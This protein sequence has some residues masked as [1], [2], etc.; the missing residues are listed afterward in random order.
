MSP[1]RNVNDVPGLY[2]DKPPCHRGLCSTLELAANTGFSCGERACPALGGKAAPTPSP[3]STRYTE[4]DGFGSAAQPSGGQAPLPQ[5]SMQ[6]PGTRCP[7]LAFLVA[8][9][10]APRWAAKPPQHPHQVLPDTPRGLVLGLL[11]S[12]AG[13]KPPCHRGLCS[14]L[15]LAATT[16]FSCGERACP[17][18]GGKAAP[19]PSPSSTRYTEG[20]GFGPAA[21][22][23]G[24]QAPLPQR[25]TQHPGRRCPPLAFLVASGL[26]PRWAAKPP[27]HPHQVLPDTPRGLVLG[28]LRSPAGDKPPFH[29]GLCSTLELAATTGFSCGERAC[30]ALGGKAAPTASPRSTRY[31]EGNGFGSATQPNGGQAPLPQRSMQ[32]PGTRCPHW[33]FLWRAGLPRAGRQSRPNSLTK[34]CQIHRGG[35]SL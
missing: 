34:S 10:L 17:A 18:L 20:N 2:R 3:R 9:G 11:R 26:A 7:P 19:T 29:R 12:P 33:L 5:R 16:G 1:V 4:G 14:T 31:T 27:Q 13:D 25:S 23:S 35:L 24:G 15:E 22:P 21:Q 6:H 28:L 8:S 30:P 32:P